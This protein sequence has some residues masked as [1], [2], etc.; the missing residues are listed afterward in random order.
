MTGQEFRERVGLFSDGQIANI[1]EFARISSQVKVIA[2]ATAEDKLI[3]VA[4][5]KQMN[6]ER[7]IVAVS[8]EGIND[9]EALV[10]SDVGMS[11]G[12]GCEITQSNSKLCL[13]NDDMEAMLRSIMWG[14]NVY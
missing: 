14:R 13:V 4:G 2:R 1:D 8:G 10:R 12:S 9:I 6:P 5:L 3:L 7:N 11:L